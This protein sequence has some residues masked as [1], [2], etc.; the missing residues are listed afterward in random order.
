MASESAPEFTV[1]FFFPGLKASR[2]RPTGEGLRRCELATGAARDVDPLVD[3]VSLRLSTDR[4]G[5]AVGATA[6]AFMRGDDRV[7]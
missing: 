4:N 1:E 7:R 3:K 2:S 6:S 5:E